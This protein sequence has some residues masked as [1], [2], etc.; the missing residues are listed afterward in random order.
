MGISFS[1]SP[2]VK[3]INLDSTKLYSFE[4]HLFDRDSQSNVG[5]D[6]DGNTYSLMASPL[7]ATTYEAVC[8]PG[9]SSVKTG[10]SIS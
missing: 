2:I 6:V 3:T 7:S 4:I 8:L 9:Y 1:G 5:I 10:N